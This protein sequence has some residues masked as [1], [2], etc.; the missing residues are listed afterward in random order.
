MPHI[1]DI[2]DMMN[3]TVRDTANMDLDH[4]QYTDTPRA[5]WDITQAHERS[6]RG[7]NRKDRT[8]APLPVD[9]LFDRANHAHPA[10]M[11]RFA[12]TY[13]GRVD[14]MLNT[15]NMGA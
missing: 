14:P 6:P 2:E 10:D 15:N 9:A 1:L 4:G 3:L 8:A 13:W 5:T 12:A 11:S 7:R